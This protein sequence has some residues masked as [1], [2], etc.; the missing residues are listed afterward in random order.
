MF[1]SV[2]VG[3]DGRSGGRDALALARTLAPEAQ[4][5]CAF[6]Y[7]YDQM[8]T[9]GSSPAYATALE[10]QAEP[11]L[12]DECGEA[13]DG[14]RRMTVAD[15]SPA[16][17]LHRVG[18]ELETDLIVIG[19]SH[20]GPAGRLLAGD[21]GR[22]TLHGAPC[23]VAVA[24]HGYRDAVGPLRTIG[25]GYDGGPEAEEALALAHELA[26][27][28]DAQLR[29]I[30]VVT[31]AQVNW[32]AHGYIVDWDGY[33]R[34]RRERAQEL[35][36][37]AAGRTGGEGEVLVGAMPRALE[38]ASG[39]LDLLVMGSRGWGATRRTLLGSAAHHVIHSAACPTLVVPRSAAEHHRTEP[40][41]GATAVA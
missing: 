39:A 32:P 5:V 3:I 33:E 35:V 27:A 29:I 23:P 16:R 18:E 9:R 15:L 20:R 28:N 24:P 36:E 22:G 10:E 6:A 26:E 13:G 2:V 31:P 12:R 11:L 19:S 1:K 8:P 4:L 38:T 21:V 17:A 41:S 14:A 30:T 37:D 25:V 7:P 34:E 40:A